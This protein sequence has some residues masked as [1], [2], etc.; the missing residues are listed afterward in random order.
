M[1]IPV[2]ADPLLQ[3]T[4]VPAALATTVTELVGL[5]SAPCPS[6]GVQVNK[7]DLKYELE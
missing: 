2:A 6:R 5:E 3:L 7:K 1:Y 4:V